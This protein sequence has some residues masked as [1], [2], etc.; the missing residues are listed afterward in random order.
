MP[1]I[2][3][4]DETGAQYLCDICGVEIQD[5]TEGTYCLICQRIF[6]LNCSADHPITQV[7]VKQIKN[8]FT[9][10]L[11]QAC[12]LNNYALNSND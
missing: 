7:E 11:N 5:E 10:I 1:V 6:C 2:V 4:E 9:P 12:A 3:N 8:H